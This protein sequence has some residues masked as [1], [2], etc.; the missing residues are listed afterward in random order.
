MRGIKKITLVLYMQYK[1][2][3]K[4][5]VNMENQIQNVSK[6]HQIWIDGIALAKWWNSHREW[7]KTKHL[8][9]RKTNSREFSVDKVISQLQS[10]FNIATAN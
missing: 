5:V 10:Y 7:L 9:G 3:L 1:M 6:C 2:F 4:I 8:T